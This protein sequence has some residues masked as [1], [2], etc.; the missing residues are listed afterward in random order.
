MN[1]RVYRSLRRVGAEEGDFA[2]ECQAQGC[3]ERVERLLIEYAARESQPLL[4]PGHAA[5]GSD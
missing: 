4:A 1:D 3:N 2:C 5:S